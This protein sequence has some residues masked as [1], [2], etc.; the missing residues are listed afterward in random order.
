[1]RFRKGMHYPHPPRGPGRKQYTMSDESLWQ[2]RHNLR[3]TR[4][5]SDRETAIIKLLIWQACFEGG[6]RRSQRALARE[7]RAWP[8]YVCKVQKQS[9]RG[10]EVLAGGQ[11]ASFDDLDQAR[12]F[13][14]RIREEEPDLLAPGRSETVPNVPRVMTADEA[15]AEQR[16]FAEEWK[17]KNPS[18]SARRVLFSV[19]IR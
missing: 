12:R 19:A 10:L 8:P 13:T 1:M 15:I 4:L 18:Y 2:R 6:P 7:L 9:A 14:E 16:G 17:R 11:R 3:R 5:R